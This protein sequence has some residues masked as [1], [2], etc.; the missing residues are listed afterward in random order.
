[1]LGHTRDLIYYDDFSSYSSKFALPKPS[2][3]Y[4]MLIK[5]KKKAW[6]YMLELVPEIYESLW[7]LLEPSL[8]VK[9]PDI[10]DWDL[11]NH[12]FDFTYKTKSLCFYEFQIEKIFNITK[13]WSY[14]RKSIVNHL[15][16]LKYLENKEIK[17]SY[18]GFCDYFG[19]LIFEG[20]DESY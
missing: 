4:E 3:H 6:R 14:Y 8:L 20:Y 5:P 12:T 19:S 13:W 10:N 11:K 15:M 17:N 9:C 2:M 7:D 16:I 1:M 18:Y